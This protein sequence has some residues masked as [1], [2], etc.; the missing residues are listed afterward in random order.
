MSITGELS[1]KKIFVTGGSRGIGLAIAL[2][3]ARDGARGR[4]GP[5]GRWP[6]DRRRSLLPAAGW[7][8]H[9]GGLR[10]GRTVTSVPAGAVSRMPGTR[11]CHRASRRPITLSPA[12]GGRI[13]SCVWK[14]DRGT[15][16][17]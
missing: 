12:S 13:A 2:R 6:A 3:A 7:G 8:R 17:D 1:G 5:A 10:I 9:A 11:S 14:T 15:V 4:H 16:R